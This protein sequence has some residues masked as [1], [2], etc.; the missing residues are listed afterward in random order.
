MNLSEYWNCTLKALEFE[1]GLGPTS[2]VDDG[3]DMTILLLEGVKWEIEYLK[4]NKLPDPLLADSDDER[5]LF[6]FLKN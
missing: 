2:I 3:G 6:V 4:N 5:E 1:D